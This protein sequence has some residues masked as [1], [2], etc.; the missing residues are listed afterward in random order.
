MAKVQAMRHSTHILLPGAEPASWIARKEMAKQRIG[1]IAL[2][3]E[4]SR[5]IAVLA[6]TVPRKELVLVNQKI[7]YSLASGG[8]E[9]RR[10][11]LLKSGAAAQ[12][13]IDTSGLH[14]LQYG[15][16][17]SIGYAAARMISSYGAIVSVFRELRKRLPDFSPTSIADFGCGPGTAI[18]AAKEIWPIDSALGIDISKSM[19]EVATAL[20]G[21]RA[22]LTTGRNTPV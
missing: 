21:R 6:K 12:A 22:R 16:L 13:G 10:L 9:Q 17:E 8:S 4:L 5:E 19:L 15:H 14:T 20:S 1:M 11:K 2:P 7:N 18:W 3:T